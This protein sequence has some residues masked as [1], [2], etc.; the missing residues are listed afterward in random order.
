MGRR[1]SIRFV[2]YVSDRALR[3][4][5]SEDPVSI[6]TRISEDVSSTFEILHR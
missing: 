6:V 2:G 1:F 5:L 4:D 3:L